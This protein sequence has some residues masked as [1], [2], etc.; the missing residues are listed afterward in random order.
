MVPEINQYDFPKFSA[1]RYHVF[2][3][4]KRARERER[5]RNLIEEL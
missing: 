3:A 5:E 1:L 4:K 2:K